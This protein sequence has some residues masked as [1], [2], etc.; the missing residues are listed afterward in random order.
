MSSTDNEI[1]VISPSSITK[2]ITGPSFGVSI[3]GRIESSEEGERILVNVS[4][5]ASATQDYL[6][7]CS[8]SLAMSRLSF[9]VKVVLA[10]A[11]L[12]EYLISVGDERVEI[13]E[14][15]LCP[16]SIFIEEETNEIF[17][18]TEGLTD[19]KEKEEMKRWKA[20]EMGDECD[21]NEEVEDDGIEKVV[22]FTLGPKLLETT[23]GEVPLSESNT[24]EVQ[25]MTRDGMR[26]LTEGIE[27]ELI[28]MIEKMWADEPFGRSAFAEV[29]WVLNLLNEY[30]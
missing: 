14:R 5:G 6:V 15:Q 7:G 10:V 20:P 23:I 21:E 25:V 17:V 19:E 3:S 22:V 13:L 2:E 30:L 24:E 12:F 28:Q 11:E 29:I 9:V 8:S 26:Q 16:Y 1:E 27:E 4:D 18:L